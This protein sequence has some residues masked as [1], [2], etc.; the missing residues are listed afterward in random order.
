MV[1]PL[2]LVVLFLSPYWQ[3]LL[4]LS[5]G[6]RAAHYP[7]CADGRRDVAGNALATTNYRRAAAPL[8]FALFLFAVGGKPAEQKLNILMTFIGSMSGAAGS[9]CR[10]ISPDLAYPRDFHRPYFYFR[11][12]SWA[13][14]IA[15][16]ACMDYRSRDSRGMRRVYDG[17]RACRW[18]FTLWRLSPMGYTAKPRHKVLNAT[19]NVGGLPLFIIG[20][21]VI[22]DGLV[23]VGQFLGARMGPPGVEQRPKVYQTD[24]RYCPGG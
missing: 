19:S 8:S 12:R 3:D 17:F 1:S 24:D 6:R 23:L 11:C 14:K 20:G 5:P 16:A 4:I 10:R 22:R 13:R 9:T 15:S 7:S 21:K 18:P 2:P